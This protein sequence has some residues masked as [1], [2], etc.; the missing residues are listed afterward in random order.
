MVFL[1]EFLF[2]VVLNHKWY[3]ITKL[4]WLFTWPIANAVCLFSTCPLE[5]VP[6]VS[7]WLS[8]LKPPVHHLLLSTLTTHCT[9][10]VYRI[11]FHCFQKCCYK[12]MFG[13]V[14]VDWHDVLFGMFGAKFAKASTCKIFR[15]SYKINTLILT[16]L[17]WCYH[18][19]SAKL[20]QKVCK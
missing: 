18:L 6:D 14:S 1:L 4:A 7:T 9:H 19:K 11:I 20:K 5:Y 16:P 13:N 2:W 15:R 10:C 8:V 3:R 17:I 12:T